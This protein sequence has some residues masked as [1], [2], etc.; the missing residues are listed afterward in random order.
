MRPVLKWSLIGCGCISSGIVGLFVLTLVVGAFAA[1]RDRTASTTTVGTATPSA[2]IVSATAAAAPPAITSPVSVQKPAVA[3]QP[4]AAPK[5]LAVAKV[6]D[7]VESGGIAL[8]VNGVRRAQESGQF[9]KAK[10][11]RTFII[12]DVGL[13]TT[14]R[15]KAP[16][17]PFYFKVKDADGFEYDGTVF[18]AENALKSG[19]L[20]QGEKVRGTVSFDV[21]S[22]A[23]GLVLAYQPI[24]IFGGYQVI[25][26]QLE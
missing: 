12:V 20:A 5:P 1:S 4:T 19:E 14:G 21:P 24:V 6:G 11:G 8:I 26:V 18:G 17:N 22:E 15:E 9:M 23:K 3:A 10:P 2:V 25:R 7:R 13:E 16:Y